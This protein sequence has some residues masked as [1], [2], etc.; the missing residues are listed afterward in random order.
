MTKL[1]QRDLWRKLRPHWSLRSLWTP[2][3]SKNWL[4][5]KLRWKSP[6]KSHQCSSLP[7]CWVMAPKLK[8]TG[9]KLNRM[10]K[11]S[12]LLKQKLPS[13]SSIG[14]HFSTEKVNHRKNSKFCNS[15]KVTRISSRLSTIMRMMGESP[16]PNL[17]QFSKFQRS[18]TAWAWSFAL[19][20][21][22]LACY[23]NMDISRIRSLSSIWCF[24]SVM[25]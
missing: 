2:K 16:Y 12:N 24:R 11:K 6:I 15:W 21:I 8:Y 5:R 25:D 4:L 3:T 20:V 19:M 18:L 10:T 14:C 22:W 23:C 7:S 1:N 9:R 17:G 13:K